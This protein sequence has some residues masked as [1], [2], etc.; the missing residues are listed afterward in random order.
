MLGNESNLSTFDKITTGYILNYALI[1]NML[2]YFKI[3]LLINYTFSSI[4]VEKVKKLTYNSLQPI[5]LFL[6]TFRALSISA[7][8]ELYPTSMNLSDR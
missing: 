3:Y 6:P 2:Y 8:I 5:M 1:Y 4:L 7:E